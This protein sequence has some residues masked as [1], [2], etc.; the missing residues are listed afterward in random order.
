MDLS[1][2]NSFF[3]HVPTDWI[4]IIAFAILVAFDAIRSGTGRACALTLSLPATLLLISELP[5]AKVLSGVAAQ[6]GTP[7]LKALLF[8]IIFIIAYFL[9]RRMSVPY[10]N[11]SG[12][13]IQALIAGI[14]TVTVV[15]VVWLQVP[16][17]NL[18]GTL[19]HRFNQC[20]AK[21]TASGG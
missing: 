5:H 8:G 1:S 2:I 10:R 17:L 16:E 12:A 4:V 19:E 14:A 20:S 15:V 13:S 18:F 3:S 11:N 21:H 7:M 9:V 6:F